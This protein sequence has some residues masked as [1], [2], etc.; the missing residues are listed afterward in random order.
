MRSIILLL[1]FGACVLSVSSAN[2]PSSLQKE[3]DAYLKP[4]SSVARNG[5]WG[6]SEFFSGPPAVFFA[7]VLAV[8]LII[9]L[10]IAAYNTLR[11]P[12]PKIGFGGGAQGGGGQ[13]WG[14]AHAGWGVAPEGWAAPAAGGGWAQASNVYPAYEA[15]AASAPQ[16]ATVA[17]AV[18][19]TVQATGQ[20]S[21]NDLTH[22]V[23]NSIE[24]G[25]Q[26]QH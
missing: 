15:P 25:E 24:R 26:A 5:G 8:G 3:Q 12:P 7:P 14:Q 20:R 21:L 19:Q 18:E 4:D 10:W 9:V 22:R 16:A 2:I 6:A 23:F 17:A 11:S 1:A 13:G